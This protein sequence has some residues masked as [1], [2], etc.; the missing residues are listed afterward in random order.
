VIKDVRTAGL[1]ER[2]AIDRA[3][4]RAKDLEWTLEMVRADL[5]D[6]EERVTTL[7]D[8]RGLETPAQV[9]PREEA[10]RRAAE[11]AVAELSRFKLGKTE[12]SKALRRARKAVEGLGDVE[13]DEPTLAL[14]AT[15]ERRQRA[16]DVLREAEAVLARAR[17][18]VAAVDEAVVELAGIADRRASA[19]IEVERLAWATYAFGASGIPSREL[20][21]A[22]G[23]AEDAMN[24][25][26]TDLGAPTQL[27]FSPSRELKEWEPACLACGSVFRKGERKHVCPDCGVP[28]RRKRRDELRLEVLDGEYTSA[29]ELDSGGGQVLLSLG[30]RLGLATLPGATRRVRCEGVI[31]DEPDG[32]LDAPNRQAL[33]RLLQNRLPTLGIRQAIL[34]T[35]ADVRHEFDSVVVVKRWADEDR[36]GAWRE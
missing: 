30:T 15:A 7:E 23:V 35:H 12:S 1:R 13:S 11:D 27:R 8:L 10:A 16:E 2:R 3:A 22:F 20:E 34:I 29:F 19:R 26:L 32:A 33:H 24:R 28:R 5:A 6:G 14:A 18:G 21:N 36:S 31:V 17:A 9:A 4:K 25:V